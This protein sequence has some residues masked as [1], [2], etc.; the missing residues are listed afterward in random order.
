MAGLS[1][2]F[3][4]LRYSLVSTLYPHTC[5]ACGTVLETENETLCEDCRY[6]LE[7]IPL[8][9]D[10]TEIAR[11]M[12]QVQLVRFMPLL[13]YRKANIESRFVLNIKNSGVRRYGIEAGRMMGRMIN[14]RVDAS[15]FD[16]L[17]PVPITDKRYAT[18]GYNQS[19][20][21]AIGI[22]QET[23]I[24][25][26]TDLLI[27]AGTVVNDSIDAKRHK[28]ATAN[29]YQAT[30]RADEMRGKHILVIDDV[31]TTGKTIRECSSAFM[32]KCDNNV[33]V[34]IAV[35]GL[36]SDLLDI[37]RDREALFTKNIFDD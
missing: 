26:R 15:E 32:E 22:E 4:A 29:N 19:E 1:D 20:L 2:V 7:Y 28:S 6:S 16:C 12:T 36:V 18:R 13:S 25:V 33:K 31:I 9:V 27:N 5:G 3:R 14:A 37:K 30:E 17:V 24:P 34:S 10:L 8:D 11:E 23:G 21:L 35:V